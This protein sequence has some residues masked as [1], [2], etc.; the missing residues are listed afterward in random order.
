M[1]ESIGGPAG[2]R[3]TSQEPSGNPCVA[4]LIEGTE[5][6]WTPTS[7]VQLGDHL[8]MSDGRSLVDDPSLTRWS[9]TLWAQR[10]REAR[11]CFIECCLDSSQKQ[12][13]RRLLLHIHFG[14]QLLTMAR[15]G[16]GFL[17]TGRH[18]SYR[19]LDVDSWSS[20]KGFV[21]P[22]R[23]SS[24]SGVTD[25]LVKEAVGLASRMLQVDESSRLS[26]GINLLGQAL[27][28]TRLQERLH[29][30]TRALEGLVK[31]TIGRSRRQF[32]HRCQTLCASGVAAA[33]A[34]KDIYD[35]RSAVEHLH[36]GLTVVAGRADKPEDVLRKRVA[37][38]EYLCTK[39]YARLLA[40]PSLVAHFSN[41]N[42]IDDFWEM[43]DDERRNVWGKQVDLVTEAEPVLCFKYPD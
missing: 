14:L 12:P 22:F 2:I 6:S 16:A 28:E 43:R 18:E 39:T 27:K 3:E 17:L 35:I 9:G 26:H 25:V 13:A 41:D 29:L 7:P 8:W 20:F 19:R 15:L 11:F 21:M 40:A 38:V 5:A 1:T 10:V 32:V 42:S 31:P 33:E 23:F 36:D 30:F 37:Q 34:L 4:L 24:T